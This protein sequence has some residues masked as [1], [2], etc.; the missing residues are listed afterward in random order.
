MYVLFG[1][2]TNQTVR[3]SVKNKNVTVCMATPLK[4]DM[5][6]EL[7]MLV[8]TTIPRELMRPAAL[9]LEKEFAVVLGKNHHLL[10]QKRTSLIGILTPNLYRNPRFST[11][12]YLMKDRLLT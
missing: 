1:W 7:V 10:N 4:A 3:P 12:L 9:L 11:D 6:M 5:Q 8:L 2:K